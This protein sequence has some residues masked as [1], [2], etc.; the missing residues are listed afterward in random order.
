MPQKPLACFLLQAD[1]QQ[2]CLAVQVQG[3]LLHDFLQLYINST[4]EKLRG[5]PCADGYALNC[6]ICKKWIINENNSK[7]R[8]L[9]VKYQEGEIHISCVCIDTHR[10]I[11]VAM[12]DKCWVENF[13][14]FNTTMKQRNWIAAGP[15]CPPANY[16]GSPRGHREARGVGSI[17]STPRSEDVAWGYTT[18]LAS[19]GFL[20][21]SSVISSM[22]MRCNNIVSPAQLMLL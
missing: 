3:L 18:Y 7:N 2:H 17:S 14:S 12:K 21:H 9:K 4:T 20:Q 1:L 6:C 11:N 5:C 19:S 13:N 8:S 15:F 16:L 10:N 22:L